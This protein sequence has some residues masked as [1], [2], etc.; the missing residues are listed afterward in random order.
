MVN[1]SCGIKD[2]GA[3][4]KNLD[5]GNGIQLYN[6]IKKEQVVLDVIGRWEVG[7]A[8]ILSSDVLIISQ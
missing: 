1:I 6:Q 5:N 3:G 4:L 7:G 2:L 8:G